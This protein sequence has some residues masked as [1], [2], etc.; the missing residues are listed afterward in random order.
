MDHY[1][2]LTKGGVKSHLLSQMTGMYIYVVYVCGVYI[3][4]A[5]CY[6]I[7]V[8]S[9]WCVHVGALFLLLVGDSSLKLTHEALQKISCLI[10]GT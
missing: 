1:G 8:G 3:M 6:L 9:V 10:P 7:R 5:G 4:Y 2:L